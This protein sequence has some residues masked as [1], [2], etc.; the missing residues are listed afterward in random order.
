M[1]QV[2]LQFNS[3]A[4]ALAVLG[5]I[6]ASALE[7]VR[8]TVAATGNGVPP[9]PSPTPAPTP[10]A[11]PR[12]ASSA[13]PASTAKPSESPASP[14]SG[15]TTGD[16]SAALDYEKDVKPIVIKVG[17]AGKRDA[18][19]ELLKKFGVAKGPEVPTDKLPAFKAE[20]EALVA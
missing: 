11:A 14:A 19:V 15:A 9:A 1:I 2:T 20:L 3:I 17:A 18:L 10:A 16:A 13:P 4:A 5:A 8:S 12:A 7:G 6:P